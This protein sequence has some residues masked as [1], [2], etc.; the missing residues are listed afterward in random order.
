MPEP[1][2]P[3]YDIG[4]KAVHGS[5]GT[6][7]ISVDVASNSSGPEHA[8]S[9]II[10]VIDISYSMDSHATM[11]GDTEGSTGLSLLVR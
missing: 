9:T 10:C 8:G 6:V 3:A 4:L 2:S 5:D 1:L 7:T 11:H